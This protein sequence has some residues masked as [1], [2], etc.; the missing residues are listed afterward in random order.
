M[1][2]EI[3]TGTLAGVHAAREGGADRVELCSGLSEGG[4]TPSL[5]LL[6]AAIRVEGI[7]KHVLIRPRGGDFLYTENDLQLMKEDIL[8][9]KEVG[10][11]GVVTG[12]LTE[13]GEVDIM[14]MERLMQAADGLSVTFHRAFDMCRHATK[15]LEEIISLGCHRILT[16]GQAA[17]AETGIPLLQ[18]LVEQAAGRIGIMP[19]CGVSPMN[20]ADILRQ[21]GARELHASARELYRSRM[22][23]RQGHVS[24]GGDGSDEYA[25]WETSVDTVRAIRQAMEE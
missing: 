11:D 23:F 20:A 14:A 13:E 16:S 18:R 9:A 3:C 25:W 21:T 5:G 1:V 6:R 19:G 8:I 4:L 17:S 7:R 12:A 15:A 22:R 2:L 10:A 24:M